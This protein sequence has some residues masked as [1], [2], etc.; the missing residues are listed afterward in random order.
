MN[1]GIK[2]KS[3]PPDDCFG[4]DTPAE[5]PG[6]IRGHLT[7]RYHAVRTASRLIAAP[8]SPEDQT[9]QSM[10]DVSPTKWHLAHTTWFF[11]TFLLKSFVNGY[12]DYDPVF[13]HL[14][15]SYYHTVGSMHPRPRRGLLSRPT[16]VEVQGYRAHVD[17]AMDRLLTTVPTRD[18]PQVETLVTLGLHHEQQ[19]QEL[20]LTDIKHVLSCNPLMPAAYPASV[21]GSAPRSVDAM[22]EAAP[23]SWREFAGGLCDIGHGADGFTFDNETPRHP[24]LV[25]AF[26]LASRPVTNGEYLEFIKDGGY[27]TVTLWL[28]DGWARIQE[29]GWRHPLYW[30]EQDGTWYEFTLH[31]MMPLDLTRPVA[32]VS[33]YEAQAFADWAGKRLPTEFELELALASA[34]KAGNLL[35]SGRPPERDTPIA[36]TAPEPQAALKAG[37]GECVQLY[38]DVWEWT[39]SAY[40]PYPGFKPLSGSLGEYNGKFMCNQFVLRG[41]S[42]ATPA[43][44]IRATYRNFFPPDACWQ[45]SG[46]RLAA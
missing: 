31:G 30:R 43:D 20:M 14:F 17:E 2:L 13:A 18:W 38:G 44:H 19:H 23:L 11:E 6:D 24:E 22:Q 25:P 45:F 41:G 42:C 10:P 15:N 36:L 16:A 4:Q 37:A 40:A 8:L 1:A 7:Q 21:P 34:P 9:I 33:F 46:I 28:S 26:S 32:H 3:G 5:D 27:D 12:Q 35:F 39:R 29:T